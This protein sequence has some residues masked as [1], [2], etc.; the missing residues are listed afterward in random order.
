MRPPAG[1]RIDQRREGLGSDSVARRVGAVCLGLLIAGG[2]AAV[3][4][5]TS[6]HTIVISTA[7]LAPFVVSV[8]AGPRETAFVGAVAITLALVSG[9]W[10]HN[11]GAGAYDLG[12]VVV[13]VGAAISVL[14][15]R[16][17][18]RTVRDRERFE[19]LAAVAEVADGRLTLEETAVRICGLTVPVF[20]DG[21]VID[22]AHEGGLRRLAARLTGR[23]AE[24]LEGRLHGRPP[25]TGDEPG[26]GAAVS[27]GRSQ[28]LAPMT[29]E[30]LRAMAREEN[31]LALLRSLRLEAVIAVPLSSRGR[32]LGALTLL[33]TADSGRT[34]SA[35]DV[36]FAEVLSGRVALALDNAGLFTE[37]Q[38]MESQLTTAL[39]NLAEAVTVQ[40]AQGGL[41]YANQ[42]AADVLGY[43]S[44]QELVATPAA[45]IVERFESYREDGSP[46]DLAD[47][48]GRRVLAGENPEPL[49]VRIVDR[50]T[51]EQRWRRTKSSAVRDSGG[52][53][54]MIVNVIADITAAKRAEVIQRLLAGAGE[55]LA[56]SLDPHQ[57]LQ[58]VADLCVPD[59][60][61]WCAVSLPDDRGALRAVAVA[62]TDP[63]KVA[64]ARRVGER[65]PARLDETS[66][67]AKVFRDRTVQYAND[68]P[69]DLLVA[70]AKD[71]EHL[72]ALRSLGMRA[73]LVVPM[74]S[75]GRSI[76]VLSLVSAESGRSFGDED[77]ALASELARRAAIAVE[78]ARLY[79]ERSSIARTLQ[80]SLLPDEVPEI[81][82]WRTAKV[83][84]PAGDENDVGGDFYEAVPLDGDWMLVVGD[85]TGRGAPAAALTG[86]MRHTLRTAATLT[87]SATRALEKLNHDLVSRPQLSLCT[88]VCLVLRDHTSPARAD[89]ICA[90][91]PAPMLVRDGSARQVGEYGPVLG[92]YADETWAACT[93]AILPG[94]V[95]VLYSDGL[96]D[97][98]GAEDRFGPERLHEVLTGVRSAS[99]AVA[100][101]EAA[102]SR[103]QVGSQADD[104]AVLAV[105]RLPV[106]VAGDDGE[107]T[108]ADGRTAERSSDPQVLSEWR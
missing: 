77:I 90:G 44:P 107:S 3:D 31:D 85:V 42:A 59:L 16:T 76:G 6:P 93:M 36:R 15:A 25:S 18:E 91:H 53:V 2:L 88:A 62:H 35:E 40:N 17:R 19:L 99:E 95:L 43:S 39:G 106:A 45:G 52:Q 108:H 103:F 14:V 29:D 84:R 48:P 96:V 70:A 102:L 58:Q 86:L 75:G 47:L 81:P 60:A 78:N 28:L 8:L 5:S 68:I 30:M 61:D 13:A 41:I 9:V 38:T 101:I 74:A 32:L 49:V 4:A 7:V 12:A 80:M 55:A 71:P 69:D 23:E 104:I 97:A 33:A 54:K 98:E 51:G 26:V 37:L 27:T 24:N 87:G 63:E 10:N 83:Y 50:T 1:F 64:L 92:A 21:C 56:S 72:D 94:D 11:F 57:T 89:I 66:G 34:F 105:E 65:Y 79:A 73:G 100:R 20:A 46:L 67:A 82:G 22:V